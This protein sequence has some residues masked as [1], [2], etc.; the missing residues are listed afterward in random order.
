VHRPEV[1]EPEGPQGQALGLD[2]LAY[3]A[4]S[5]RD[6]PIFVPSM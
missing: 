1:G 5:A 2:P 4:T 6:V 3:C